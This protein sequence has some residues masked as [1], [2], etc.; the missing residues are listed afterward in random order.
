MVAEHPGVAERRP[1]LVVALD[2]AHGGVHIDHQPGRARPGAQR[3]R[4]AHHLAHHRLELA[5]MSEGERPQERAERRGR[6]HPMGHDPLGATPE[7]STS[8]WS[9]WEAPTTMGAP[10]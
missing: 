4:P 5:D 10:R 6:H 8:A 1:L 9:T 3:P 7:R 2:L